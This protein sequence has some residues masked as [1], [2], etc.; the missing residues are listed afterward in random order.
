MKLQPYSVD[1]T[2]TSLV[3]GEKHMYP[4]KSYSGGV[5]LDYLLN[6]SHL[7]IGGESTE[8]CS[9]HVCVCMLER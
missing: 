6:D 9:G 2:F 4:H 3:S 1:V 5:G 8:G 7:L